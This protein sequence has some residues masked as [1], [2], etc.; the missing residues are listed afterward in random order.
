MVWQMNKDYY[1]ILGIEKTAT[2]LEIKRAYR[3]LAH[4][5]HPDKGNGDD[6]KFKEVSEAYQVLSDPEKR[7]QYDQ[8]GHTFEHTTTGAGPGGFD[9]SGFD[10]GQGQ[11]VEFDFTNLGDIFD[12]FF[13]REKTREERGRD[14]EA[15]AIISFEDSFSDTKQTLEIE[16]NIICD[17]CKGE[18]AEPGTKL[19]DCPECQGKGKKETIRR[20]ILGQ[21]KSIATCQNCQ[22]EGKIPETKCGKCNGAG[23]E[24]KKVTLEINIPAGIKNG[25]TVRVAGAGDQVSKGIPGDLYLVVFVKE[26]PD[27]ERKNDDIIYNAKIS[28][29]QATLGD[30]ILVPTMKGEKEIRIKSGTQSGEKI[31]LRGLGF[32][33]LNSYGRGN[34]IIE[35]E[36]ITPKKLS[37][38]QKKLF[39]KL[40]SFE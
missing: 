39:E 11:G 36:I 7:K 38:E 20:T 33:H 21:F 14:L 22:G 26:H 29:S 2:E 1:K 3:K 28:F 8:F 25:M 30:K 18:K 37:R 23:I 17:R 19:V 40:K 15:T 34:Q 4:K 12:A 6:Q 35:I 16:K 10:F 31:V 32:P 24:H 9:F 13:G 5:Y 27:F